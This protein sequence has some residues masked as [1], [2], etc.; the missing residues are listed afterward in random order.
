MGKCGHRGHRDRAQRV[1]GQ[2]LECWLRPRTLYPDRSSIIASDPR[3]PPNLTRTAHS[4][5]PPGAGGLAVHLRMTL[6][7]VTVASKRFEF[8]KIVV[9]GSF[10]NPCHMHSN[11]YY[12]V[13]TTTQTNYILSNESKFA[14]GSRWEASLSMARGG[15]I[16]TPLRLSRTLAVCDCVTVYSSAHVEMPKSKRESQLNFPLIY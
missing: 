5:D 11:R 1:S 12:S 10:V 15:C 7:K 4:A 2:P 3:L 16:S 13:S 8:G 6:N 14:M 9:I